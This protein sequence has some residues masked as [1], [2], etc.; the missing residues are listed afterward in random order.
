MSHDC[1][2]EKLV[3]DDGD[4]EQMSWHDATIY[5][6]AFGPNEFELSLDIDYIFKWAHPLEGEEFFRF[7]VAPCTL[8]FQNV[9]DLR[10]DAA[11]YGGPMLE[12]DNISRSDPQKPKNAKFIG[13]DLEWQWTL[14][15]HHGEISFRSVGFSQYVRKAP[16]LTQAQSLDFSERGGFSFDRGSNNDVQSP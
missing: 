7:L 11:P 6:I 1:K 4:F 2:I 14:E 16:L 13:R 3:W 10:L 9:Y 15:C 8:V 12:I 5:G